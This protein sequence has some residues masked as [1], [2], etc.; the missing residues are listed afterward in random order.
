[1]NN[2]RPIFN[3]RIIAVAIIFHIRIPELIS[4]KILGYWG[5]KTFTVVTLPFV[6]ASMFCSRPLSTKWHQS[7]F[8]TNVTVLKLINFIQ[9]SF[10][11]NKNG[12]KLHDNQK[13]F[14]Y[15]KWT[16]HVHLTV[17]ARLST[18]MIP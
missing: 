4:M 18:S 6:K 8:K 2:L 5:Q 9:V 14:I 1:M 3:V 7:N 15:R 11:L 16:K 12:L 17:F 10:H 13:Y